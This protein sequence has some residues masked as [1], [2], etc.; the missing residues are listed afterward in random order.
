MEYS[1]F[2]TYIQSP[3]QS[4]SRKEAELAASATLESI[5]ERVPVAQLPQ[6]LSD[7]FQ[8]REEESNQSFHLQDFI[9]RTGQKEHIELT[10]AIMHIREVFAVLQN[11]I[12]SDI[13]A[14]FHAQFSWDYKELL[15]H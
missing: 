2:I 1:Q 3:A 7:C 14:K 8:W 13:F 11:T 6:E 5:K 12:S 10:T 9:I 4:N 15:L